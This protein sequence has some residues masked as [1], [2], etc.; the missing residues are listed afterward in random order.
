MFP[1]FFNIDIN[2]LGVF[3]ILEWGIV[4]RLFQNSEKTK[5]TFNKNTSYDIWKK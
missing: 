5:K 2:P 3:V 4:S 1:H